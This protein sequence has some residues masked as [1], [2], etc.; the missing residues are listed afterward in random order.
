MPELPE[1]ETVVRGLRPVLVSRIHPA[2]P[3]T[4]LARRKLAA[5]HT[6]APLSAV[7]L[8]RRRPRFSAG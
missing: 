7:L 6:P 3:T 1:V 2:R 8:S 4:S 5:L